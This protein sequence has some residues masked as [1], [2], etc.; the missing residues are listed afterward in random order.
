MYDFSERVPFDVVPVP[1]GTFR[2]TVGPYAS[3]FAFVNPATAAYYAM[4]VQRVND[5]GLLIPE[6]RFSPDLN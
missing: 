5:D 4:R 1:D 6:A 3:K 2:Y